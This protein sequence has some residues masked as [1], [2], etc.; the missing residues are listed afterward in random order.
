MEE[1]L[2]FLKTQPV[3]KQNANE[4]QNL[5]TTPGSEGSSSPI[6]GGVKTNAAGKVK[7]PTTVPAKTPAK[8]ATPKKKQP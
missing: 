4:S 8:P 6:A 1:S 7:T 3:T 2:D 5:K